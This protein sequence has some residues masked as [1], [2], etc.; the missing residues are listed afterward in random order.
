MEKC[1][2]EPI[3]SL[4]N[5]IAINP[6]F[7]FKEPIYFRMERGE[8]IAIVGPTDRAKAFW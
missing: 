3:I 2:K 4:T 7:R 6:L 5:G 1:Y 8:Q